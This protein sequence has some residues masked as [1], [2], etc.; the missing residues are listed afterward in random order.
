M[1]ERWLT[2]SMSRTRPWRLQRARWVSDQQA[3]RPGRFHL[4]VMLYTRDTG[5]F[6]ESGTLGKLRLAR[7]F[8]RANVAYAS[9]WLT[10]RRHR[11]A[12]VRQVPV[13]ESL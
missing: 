4:K 1:T 8:T 9:T 7:A 2:K 13:P 3:R 12:A 6:Q 11:A 5:Q 10:L